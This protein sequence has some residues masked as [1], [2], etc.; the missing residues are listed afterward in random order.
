MYQL[1]YEET[2]AL[3]KQPR[4]MAKTAQKDPFFGLHQRLHLCANVS[5]P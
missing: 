5:L 1:G 3:G 2:V 4:I